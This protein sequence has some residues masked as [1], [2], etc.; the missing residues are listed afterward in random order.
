MKLWYILQPKFVHFHPL[1]FHTLLINTLFQR[2]AIGP[3]NSN[4]TIESTDIFSPN[5]WCPNPTI[6]WP[7]V[8][9]VLPAWLLFVSFF[10]KKIES[11]SCVSETKENANSSTHDKLDGNCNNNESPY[12]TFRIFGARLFWDLGGPRWKV[13]LCDPPSQQLSLPPVPVILFVCFD[14]RIASFYIIPWLLLFMH[15]VY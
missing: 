12:C 6:Y 2:N 14:T 10:A 13:K 15:V 4:K 11:F 5:Q 9:H 7:V 3:H 1:Q 8:T